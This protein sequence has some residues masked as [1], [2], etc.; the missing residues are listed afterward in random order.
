MC[1]L[2]PVFKFIFMIL[3]AKY[4]PLSHK[5]TTQ[6][7]FNAKS[8]LFLL[9]AAIFL[10]SCMAE[11]QMPMPLWPEGQIPG[12]LRNDTVVE[13]K[14]TDKNGVLRYSDVRI[15]TLTVWVPKTKQRTDAAVLIIP[16][17]GY[18]IVAAG[19]EGEDLAK[20]YNRL[21]IT[22]FVLKYRLPDP[23]LWA[24]PREA[25]LQDARRAMTIIRAGATQ[26]GIDPAK[27][28]VMGFSAGG[29][30]ASTLCTHDAE[31]AALT[32]QTRPNWAVLGYPV[33]TFG[34]QCHK[35]SKERLLGPDKDNQV[36]VEAYSN[37][38]R[39]TAQTPPTFIVHSTDDK[40]VPVEN[41][42]LYYEALKTA[43]VSADLH[44]YNRGGHGYGLGTGRKDAP[45]EWPDALSAW[46]K[47]MDYTKK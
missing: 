43:G 4:C 18:W 42:L 20:W 44:V 24:Y 35:G 27:V 7:H 38:G 8:N 23:R 19:H 33:I 29:H 14:I 12:A 9:L 26:W 37:E 45:T 5:T 32:N 28:G 2:A 47:R 1:Y 40:T 6:Y 25:P 22:A 15:P 3:R 31:T 36:L 30:L 21:G 16:G 39:V 34:P 11:A 13:Q 10:K 46:L 17:G 41:A